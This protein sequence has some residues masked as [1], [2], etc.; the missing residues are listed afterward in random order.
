M[1]AKTRRDKIGHKNK[2]RRRRFV[3][4]DSEAEITEEEDLRAANEASSARMKRKMTELTGV[5][6]EMVINDSLEKMSDILLDYAEPLLSVIDSDDKLEYEKALMMAIVLWNYSIMKE[7]SG[8]IKRIKRI[9]SM[10]RML[11]PFMADAE[12]RSVLNYMLE[13]KRQMYPDNKRVILNY[14]L[15]EGRKNFHL[16]VVSSQ[17]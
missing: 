3:E 2:I 15:T 11:R 14:E 1:R 9:W 13:R 16:F 8:R 10:R 5:E 4:A 12:S 7:T 6:H 17:E